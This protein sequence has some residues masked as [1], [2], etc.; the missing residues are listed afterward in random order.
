MCLD[1]KE[2]SIK[3]IALVNVVCYKFLIQNSDGT[4][5]TPYQ[6][7]PVKIGEEYTAVMDY[8]DHNVFAGLHSFRSKKDCLFFSR[9]WNSNIKIVKCIIPF[10]SRYFKGR[11]D[12]FR[13]FASNKIKYIKEI[14]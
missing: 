5:K 11:F 1:R 6:S 3:R 7:T 2:Y 4:F 14:V 9:N 8:T 12:G 10:G 13:G